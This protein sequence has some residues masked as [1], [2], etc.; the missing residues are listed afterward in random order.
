MEV[1][2]FLCFD[3][4]VGI[5]CAEL[6]DPL[7]PPQGATGPFTISGNNRR[8]ISLELIAEDPAN[9]EKFSFVLFFCSLFART[10]VSTIYC[11]PDPHE[12]QQYEIIKRIGMEENISNEV[13]VNMTDWQKLLQVRYAFSW[14]WFHLLVG[15]SCL[16]WSTKSV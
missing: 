8:E 2:L 15:S 11:F 7:S 5:S 4:C 13:Y 6:L 12:P 9:K 3:C 1:F 16:T 14:A 10:F